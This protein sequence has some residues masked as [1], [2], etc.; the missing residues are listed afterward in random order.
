[1]LVN[2][3][4][5]VEHIISPIEHGL[6]L[7]HFGEIFIIVVVVLRCCCYVVVVVVVVVAVA[8]VPT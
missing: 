1:M 2:M 3:S 4:K 5:K 8:V 6:S 7:Q